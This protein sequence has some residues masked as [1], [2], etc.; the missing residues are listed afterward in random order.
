M[1]KRSAI[2]VAIILMSIGFASVSTTL[3][4]NGNAKISEGIDDFDIYFSKAF[5]DNIDVYKSVVSQDKKSITFT[6]SEL[7]TLGQTS[8]LTYEVTNNSSN[9]DANVTVACVPKEGTTAKY[10]SIKNEFDG[11]ASK[12]LARNSLNG[13]LTITLNKTSIE[14][15]TEEYV[16]KL[17]FNAVERTK[18]G[19]SNNKP[20]EPELTNNLVPVSI[21]D[22]GTVKK[23]NIIKKWYSYEDKVWA[24]AI[25]LNDDYDDLSENGKINGATKE[26]DG[27]LFDGVDDYVELGFENYDFK[28]VLTLVTKFKVNSLNN[29]SED[30][31][32]NWEGAGGG[33]YINSFNKIVVELYSSSQKKYVKVESTE[34][35]EVGKEY[36]VISRYDGKNIS[37]FINGALIGKSSLTGTLKASTMPITLGA[38]P[39][40]SCHIDYANILVKKVV[41]YDR[42]LSEE[43][44]TKYYKD[45]IV[46]ND[47][48]DLLRYVNFEG[49]ISN[50]EII[51][52]E[53]IQSYFV[54]IPRFRY[55]L[56]NVDNVDISNVASAADVE[57]KTQEIE[58]EFESKYDKVSNGT[59]NGEWLTHPAFTTFDSNGFWVGKFDTGYKGATTSTEALSN[60]NESSKIVIKPNVYSWRGLNVR[61]AYNAAYNYNTTSNSHM[62]KNTEWGAVAYLSN[63]KYGVNG[64][65][66]INNNSSFKTGYSA[67]LSTNQ[68]TSPGESGDGEEYNS[69]YNTKIGYLASTTGNISGIYD[70]VG[71]A[72]EFVA[73]YVDGQTGTEI[74]QVYDSKFYDVYSQNALDSFYKYRILGDATGEMGPFYKYND[75]DGKLRTHGSWYSSISNSISTSYPILFR[76]GT[77]SSGSGASQFHF[78]ITTGHQA[79]NTG[80]RIVL[81]S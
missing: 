23:A 59:R 7:K 66:N 44:I 17:E 26:N 20:E 33:I 9:Y 11:N 48:T 12:V 46:I 37:L 65:I 73:A 78:N 31:I 40:S 28:D 32:G 45:D 43:E 67:L 76:G 41:L 63:S 3:L 4:I 53:K 14:E 70:M 80:F 71:G 2:I 69:S 75:G 15:I 25:I 55:K 35:V 6:T 19:T 64:K 47:D 8:M 49:T 58:I 34:K 68:Q 13:T 18:I 1:K 74:F 72:Q 62:I 79:S 36:V 77:N 51:P 16:C 56:F 42:A 30:I 39:E 22:N 10:T 38:N 29:H 60:T 54:W 57:S 61:N 5:I 81:V 24:N 21:A 52:E 27:V 50:D